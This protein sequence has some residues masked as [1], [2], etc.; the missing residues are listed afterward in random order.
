MCI[1]THELLCSLLINMGKGPLITFWP[2]L[3][4]HGKSGCST[5]YVVAIINLSSVIFFSENCMTV[6]MLSLIKT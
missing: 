5:L 3:I 4:S 6:K 2:M 1:C